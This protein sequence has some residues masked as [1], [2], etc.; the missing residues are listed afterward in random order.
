M[1]SYVLDPSALSHGLD[2][3]ALDHLNHKMITYNSSDISL[4]SA[5]GISFTGDQVF[6]DGISYTV[7][8]TAVPTNVTLIITEV[9]NKLGFT[10]HD[11]AEIVEKI[12]EI[13]KK[14]L[15]NR[16]DVLISGFGK[17]CVKEKEKRRGRNPST[18]ETIILRAIKVVTFK[19]SGKLKEMIN[20][21]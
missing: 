16:E 6:T 4:I 9:T 13:I 20:S 19:T 11:S 12:L 3:I 17:F 5:T 14:T 15:E 18:G 1:A 2:R 7:T 8:A 10:K 21:G